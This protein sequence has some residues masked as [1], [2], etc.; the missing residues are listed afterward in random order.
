VVLHIDKE[1]PVEHLVK[2]AGIATALNAKV[3][4]ATSPEITP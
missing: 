2:V 4:I 3:S 1:V